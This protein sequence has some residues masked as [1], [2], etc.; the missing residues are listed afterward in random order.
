MF[1]D[2]SVEGVKG[3]PTADETVR[4]E[5]PPDMGIM[6]SPPLLILDEELN[7]MDSSGL[8]S[9]PKKILWLVLVDVG[10]SNFCGVHD[11]EVVVGVPA[12]DPS[13]SE[14][15]SLIVHKTGDPIS[16]ILDDV[17]LLLL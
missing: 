1:P 10:V 12:S 11:V 9:G 17:F 13:P 4:S 16:F 6:I 8:K 3:D 2:P 14:C 7:D 5:L 15:T